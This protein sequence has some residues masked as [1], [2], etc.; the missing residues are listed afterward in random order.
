MQRDDD[1]DY[2]HGFLD[3]NACLSENQKLKQQSVRTTRE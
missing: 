3:E 2:A 1:D